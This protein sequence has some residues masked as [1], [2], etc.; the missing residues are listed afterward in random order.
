MSSEKVEEH[1]DWLEEEVGAVIGRLRLDKPTF[2]LVL[3]IK[4]LVREV[5]TTALCR[6]KQGQAQ[7]SPGDLAWRAISARL[8]PLFTPTYVS[9]ALQNEAYQWLGE[10]FYRR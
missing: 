2:A 3:H 4:K 10:Y 9:T 1:Q 5:E 8:Y 6:E 7:V